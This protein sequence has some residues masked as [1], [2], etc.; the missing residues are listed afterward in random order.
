MRVMAGRATRVAIQRAAR[1]VGAGAARTATE[2][3]AVRR[4]PTDV[5]VQIGQRFVAVYVE[6]GRTAGGDGRSAAGRVAAAGIRGGVVVV[7]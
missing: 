4:M 2:R 5:R 7:W 1:L 6:T 3:L